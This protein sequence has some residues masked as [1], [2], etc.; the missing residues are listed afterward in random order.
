MSRLDALQ[1]RVLAELAGRVEGW[2]LTGGAA[3]VGYHLHHRTTEDLDLF[4]GGRRTFDR[5]P[6]DVAAVLTDAG[7]DVDV[8][9][10]TPGFVR[11]SVRDAATGAAITV[12]LVAEPIPTL[13]DPVQRPPGIWVDTPQEILVNKLTALLSRS[14]L[15]DLEDVRALVAAGADLDRAMSD[16]PKKDGGFTA[17]TLAWLLTQLPLHR[18]PELG[19]DADA[20]TAFRDAWVDDL[21][22]GG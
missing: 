9:Q 19:F 16:A 11:L 3:L 12:D 4:F 2:R 17:M 21:S 15:R 8:L 6:A 7:L 14:E 22:N 20:L 1:Q 18:A 13:I 10:R 5:E